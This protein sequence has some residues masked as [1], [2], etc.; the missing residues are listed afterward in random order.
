MISVNNISVQ[1]GST[2][3]LDD[4]SMKMPHGKLSIL[5]G[6]NGAGKSTLLKAICANIEPEKGT[7]YFDGASLSNIKADEIAR[8]RA[9]VL[10]KSHLSFSFT[11][12]EIVLMG[13]TPHTN[14]FEGEKDYQIAEDCMK[15]LQVEHLRDRQFP[16]LSGGEQ[17]RVQLARAL[18]QIWDCIAENKPCYLLLDEPTSSLDIAHQHQLLS[19]L[20][21]MAQ[22]GVTIFV[23]LHDLNLAA[24]YGD[25]IHVM[26]KGK[27]IASGPANTIFQPDVIENAFECPV[28]IMHNPHFDCPLIISASERKQ[29]ETFQH[30]DTLYKINA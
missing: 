30:N 28:K 9:V 17:Q 5:V 22:A 26:K 10:Q 15:K 6:T 16:T 21:E 12:F 8:K 1:I 14:G 11:A 25:L 18:A 20:R 23:I 2:K 29:F 19:L 27:C 24:Q 13:R 3:I 7:I 4:V